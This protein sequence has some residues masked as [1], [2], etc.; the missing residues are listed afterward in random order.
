MKK[1][2][3]ISKC[4]N[5]RYEL[6]RYWD[7]YDGENSVIWIMLNPSTADAL[8]D[9]PT[10]RKCIGFSK[11]LGYSGMTVINLFAYRVTKPKFLA[12]VSDPFGPINLEIQEMA[13]RSW[14]PII[15]AWGR[16][17]SLHSAGNAM[18]SRIGDTSYC[19]GLTKNGQPLH[20]LM[21]PYSTPLMRYSQTLQELK[22]TFIKR[23][24]QIATC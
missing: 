2:A 7:N 5:Y 19:F 9:D 11:R 20:P 18:L 4:G 13:F 14:R 10:I 1:S 17:G 12:N 15:M 23:C 6:T 22:F 24:R 3:I 21:L 8:T 16:N